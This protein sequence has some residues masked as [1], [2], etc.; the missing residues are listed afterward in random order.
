MRRHFKIR[1]T[2]LMLRDPIELEIFK[3]I[4]HS[5]AEEMGAALRRTAFSPNIKE[6]RDYSCAVFDA[7]GE[8][9]AMGDHMPVHLG[10]MPM[11]VAA[12]IEAG[13]MHDGDVVMLNDPFRGGTH[14]P[15]I[16]LVAPVYVR[17]SKLHKNHSVRPDFYV[18]SRAHHADVGGAYP[19]SMGLCREIYQEGVRIPPVKLL[20]AGA[21]NMEVRAMLLTNVRTP[22]EREG[23]LG[24]QIAA[25]HTGAERLRDVCHRYGTERVRRAAAELQDYSEELMRAFLRQVPSGKYQAEDFLDSDGITDKP[26]KISVHIQVNSGRARGRTPPGYKQ[27]VVNFIGSDPQVEG[28]VNAVAAITYS[29]CFYVF[30]CLLTEDVPAAA[31]LMRPIEVIAPE[32]TVVNARPPAA[33][34]GGNVETSQRIVDVLLRA[35]SQAIPDRIPAAA[36][37]TMNN[38]T[39]GGTDPRTGEPFTYYETIAGGMGAR[40][41]KPGVSGIHTHMTNSLNTPAEALEYA[42]PLRVRSY[43]LRR[44]SGGEGEFRGG[45]GIVREIEVLTDCDVTLLADRRARAP[46]GLAGG[47]DGAPGKSFITRHNGTTESVPGKFS[48]RLHKGE[49]ITIE[50]PGGGGWGRRDLATD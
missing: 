35:L 32:G 37:G 47:V 11:S 23:D 48:T 28:S 41:G 13:P 45:D 1:Y 36:S 39:I 7:K 44:G 4:Y 38:L 12:A 24:A 21:K 14:L 27:V 15:D 50:T 43:S 33:V 5:I 49:R 18:A 9:I 29:A 30:R 8:V 3:S 6:R 2:S 26:V 22:D 16:T 40:C 42:Y 34:A 17:K 20:R 46:W 25:C 19:G 10:S 31:G